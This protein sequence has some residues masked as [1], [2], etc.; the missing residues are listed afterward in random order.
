MRDPAVPLAFGDARV[1]LVD[2]RDVGSATAAALRTV[3][4]EDAHRE[5]V[6]T[7]TGPH[8][9]TGAELVAALAAAGGR[10]LTHRDLSPA[11]LAELLK[12]AGAPQAMTR[13]L[14]ELFGYFR[15]AA[16]GHITGDVATLTGRAPFSLADYLT[17]PAGQAMFDER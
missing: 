17:T 2:A 6:F 13:L 10:R 12:A 4:G 11:D 15:T 1:N 5:R 7:L 16:L 14:G 3:R 8:S 9:F